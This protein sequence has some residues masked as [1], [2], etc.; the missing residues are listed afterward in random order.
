MSGK[1]K[2]KQVKKAAQKAKNTAPDWRWWALLPVILA[3]LLYVNT[4]GHGHVLDDFPVF[5]NN[6][7]V[8]EGVNGIP[9]LLSSNYLNGFGGFNDGLYRPLSQIT[10][11]IEQDLFGGAHHGVN[12]LLYALTGWFLFL[13]LKLLFKD[14]PL[15]L[16]LTV[17]LLF[18]AHPIHTE[19][20]ANL[21][22]RDEMLTFLNMVLAGI[23]FLKYVQAN[24]VKNL[25]LG[26]FFFVLAF[27]SKESAVTFVVALPLL[28]YF[29]GQGD[30]TQLGTIAGGLAA[31]SA[32][33]LFIRYRVIK[34]MELPVD[35]G[36][37]SY[38]Q[39]S[40]LA[41]DSWVDRIATGAYLQWMYFIK[42][43]FP[44][45][46]SFDYSFNQ[47][48]VVG[49]GS[50][51]T[52]LA[53]IAI[54]GTVYLIWKGWK[55]KEPL[56]SG[57]LFYYVTIAV[58]A[59][60]FV[61]IGAT[62]AER[63][64]YTPSLGFC[65]VL[66][67]LLMK[68]VKTNHPTPLANFKANPAFAGLL[69]VVL[70]GYSFK[71]FSRNQDWKSNLDLYTAD[72]VTSSNSAR[73]HYSYGTAI[74]N[75]AVYVTN[76]QQK[77][78]LYQEAEN[79]LI[80]A[81]NIYPEYYDAYNN[82]GLT[83]SETQKFPQA[84]QIFKKLLS[85]NPEYYKG[86]FNLSVA[87][88]KQNNVQEAITSMQQYVKTQPN[89]AK[90]HYQLGVLFGKIQQFDQAIRSLETSRQLNPNDTETLLFLGQA[91]GIQKDN[92]KA[93]AYFNQVLQIN[94]RHSGA[95]FNLGLGSMFSGQFA[96][97]AQYLESALQI[98]PENRMARE[99]IIE[100]YT[101]LGNTQK[102][103]LHRNQL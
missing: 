23:F 31:C 46:L 50:W 32:V 48:P 91:Y 17:S 22:G 87:L 28:L 100:A 68:L 89:N 25:L 94:P 8:L 64:L 15:L 70:L 83:Y 40:V 77:A 44:H 65:L 85:I 54:G 59:N 93:V 20:V 38:F 47:I 29:S 82:L 2:Q 62:F 96:Q 24:H 5:V 92:A 27:L 7:H 11:A 61:Y 101:N 57:I 76:A 41:T 12:I 86:Y 55:N 90:G 45:P 60:V 35:E 9:K 4:L 79:S 18:I 3:I 98:E 6:S 52:W 74:K 84:V 103:N 99:R 75:Q 39:N 67:W 37:L 21:K 81:I 1:R 33:L 95:Y 66:G 97:A 10:F 16:P 36:I 53:L 71:T 88:D 13:F 72:V 102:A 58:V 34:S 42:L 80:K 73:A 30:K 78:N 19:A 14:S 56:A 69:I 43:I 51:Q 63:F 26:L 49:L